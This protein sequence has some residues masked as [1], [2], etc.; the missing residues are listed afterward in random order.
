LGVEHRKRTTIAVELAAKPRFLLFLDEPTSGL[1]SQSAWSIMLLLRGLADNGQAI[2]CTIHQPSAELFQAFDRMLL[3]GKGG[4]TVYFGDLG[5]NATTLINY[6][7]RNG[8]R[9]CHP[10]E[11]PAEFM[12]DVIGAGATATS[13]LDWHG[14]WLKSEESNRVQMEITNI[15]EVGRSRPLAEATLHREFATDW[16]YQVVLLVK[17]NAQAYW[18]DPTYLMSKLAL[19]IFS[20]IFIGFTFWRQKNSQQGTQNKLFAVLTFAPIFSVPMS[21]QLQVPFIA[22]RN[23]YEIRERPSRMYSWTALITSQIL[24]EIP[25]NILA[26]TLLYFCWY[27]TIA[28]EPSR[29]GYTY[30]ALGIVY[31]LYYQSIGQVLLTLTFHSDTPLTVSTVMVFCS[32]ST[33]WV[34]GSGCTPF[35][36]TFSRQFI[37]TYSRYHVSPYTYLTEGLLGQAIGHQELQCSAVEF[38]QLNPPSGK[39][40]AQYMN[41]FIVLAG[42]YLTNPDATS[43]C[44][45]CSV[46]SSDQFLASTYNIFYS[47]R[48]RNI[49]I[50]CAFIAFNVSHLVQFKCLHLTRFNRFSVPIFLPIYFTFV[51]QV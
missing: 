16:F 25:W 47:H 51:R 17:R 38:V 46:R 34:G 29:A 10:D 22:T 23:I 6:F 11:N 5:K 19:N 33:N 7:E 44:S 24:I 43:D 35:M 45:F 1:D 3:L 15:H 30:L 50:M 27:W 4:Q 42:G 39:T 13:E 12:L 8:S 2:L 41:N 18:R 26:S 36:Q 28:F 31:P 37:L 14:V 49:G 40:C 21:N 32:L 20:G 9:S 48:W